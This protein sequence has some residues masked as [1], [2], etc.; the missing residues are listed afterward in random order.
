M[1]ATLQSKFANYR[2]TCPITHIED[3]CVTFIRDEKFLSYL[4]A[5]K[6]DIWLITYPRFERKIAEYQSNWCP[7]VKVH[8]TEWPEYEFTVYHNYLQKDVRQSKA[9]VGHRCDIHPTVVMDVDGLKMVHGPN[10]EKIHFIHSGHVM[11][12][13]DV[14]IGPYT[15]IHRGTMQVTNI[16]SGCVIGAKSNIGHNCVIGVGTVIAAGVILNGGVYTGENCWI[17]SGAMIK[18][19]V[20]ITDNVVIGMG[21]VVTKDITESGIYVGNPAKFL[22]PVEEGWN[23]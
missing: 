23:F 18:H 2:N 15:V 4:Q 9:Y 22:K 16:K 11:I 3:K 1:L 10:G 21:A 14:R 7:T 13:D 12:G 20:T 19:Y 8:Y 17:S 6:E 5:V